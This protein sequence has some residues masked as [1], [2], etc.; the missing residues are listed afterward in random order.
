M[1][2]V[3]REGDKWLEARARWEADPKLT[4]GDLA[5]SLG[6]SKQA[7]SQHAKKYG[8]AKRLDMP[9][10]AARAH[11]R[12]DRAIE[13]DSV[14]SSAN[15]ADVYAPR[16]FSSPAGVRPA[17]SPDASP[18]E[19]AQA[20]ADAAVDARAELLTRHRR[21]WGAVR[22]L[23]YAAIKEK[24]LT[25]ARTAKTAAEAVKVIQDGERKAWGLDSGEEGPVKVIVERRGA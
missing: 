21:E 11:E 25:R 12:A 15:A 1:A 7:A 24:D 13:Q 9:A 5:E 16:P 14:G 10:I 3:K 8:W 19:A 23:A 6:V 22:N 17:I 4:F 2:E 18:D 20:A